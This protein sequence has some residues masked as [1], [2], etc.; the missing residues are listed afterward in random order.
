M[1]VKACRPYAIV[2]ALSIS[3]GACTYP[4]TKEITAFADSASAVSTL[5][6]SAAQLDVELDAKVKASRLAV[7]FSKGHFDEHFPPPKGQ[8]LDGSVDKDWAVR[9][10]VL[11]A[12]IAYA[13]AIRA[14]SDPAQG[15]Q[16][17]DSLSGLSLALSNF[18][19]AS[20]NQI[21]NTRER[22]ARLA[23][24]QRIQLAGDIIASAAGY[25]VNAYA[26]F[27]V[28]QTMQR[29][30]PA[31]VEIVDILK[32]DFD[33]LAS[34][35][36]S[37]RLVYV[38]VLRTKL[39]VQAK[40]PLLTSAQKYDLYL[41]A[42]SE[43]GTLQERVEVVQDF[44]KVLDKLVQAHANLKDHTDDKAALLGFL[45]MTQDLAAKVK[46]LQDFERSQKT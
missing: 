6:K 44:S 39:A 33:G 41:A 17:R 19:A 3:V 7:E 13:D 40:D 11:N 37:K 1:F 31:L 10:A 20:A 28:R 15:T 12:M 21:A 34:A 8:F 32:Q 4:G 5:G 45:A 42:V 27:E 22:A 43:V 9:M 24:A 16:V 14:A 2:A 30:H 26:A 46:K 23:D 29:V 25:A 35:I 36:D 18:A 38:R